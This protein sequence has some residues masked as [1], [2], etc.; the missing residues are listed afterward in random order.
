MLHALQHPP[1]CTSARKLVCDLNSN[2]GFGCQMHHAVHCLAHAVA[3]NRTLIL[4]VGLVCVC[5]HV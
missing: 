5:V 3:L 1:D 4:K 2:C